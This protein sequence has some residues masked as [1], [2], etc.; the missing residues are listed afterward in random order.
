M[1][2]GKAKEILPNRLKIL[3]HKN[4]Y[5][6]ALDSHRIIHAWAFRL[7]NILTFEPLEY[8]GQCVQVLKVGPNPH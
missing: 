8:W 2:L 4:D 6:V 5:Y 7:C 3:Q 1:G